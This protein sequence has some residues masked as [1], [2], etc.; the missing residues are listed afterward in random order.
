MSV[1]EKPNEPGLWTREGKFYRVFD[2]DGKLQPVE[3]H[4][5]G[6]EGD[7]PELSDLPT[8]N[9]RKLTAP[10]APSPEVIEGIHPE[11]VLSATEWKS[12]RYMIE[13]IEA[14]A[15]K[16]TMPQREKDAIQVLKNLLSAPAEGVTDD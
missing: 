16:N 5:D 3:I 11:L 10:A 8:G 15:D 2:Y 12:C 7:W 4:V 1:S 14:Y 13:R 6:V 9:W